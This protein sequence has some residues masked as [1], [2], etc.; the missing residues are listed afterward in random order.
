MGEVE[1]FQLRD[2]REQ[3]GQAIVRADFE[4]AGERECLKLLAG[5]ADCR[6]CVCSNRTAT[7]TAVF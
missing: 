3:S 1:A 5:G 2:L 6:D 4:A 7:R